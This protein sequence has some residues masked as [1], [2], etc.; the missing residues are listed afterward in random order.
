MEQK[1]RKEKKSQHSRKK[2][3]HPPHQDRHQ[4]LSKPSSC[5]VLHSHSLHPPPRPP[6]PTKPTTTTLRTAP[7]RLQHSV[8]GFQARLGRV[9]HAP[10]DRRARPHG[11]DLAQRAGEEDVR[12]DARFAR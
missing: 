11:V 5:P 10:L 7:P 3:P 6:P 4:S 8:A 9:G 2:T 12:L 1:K